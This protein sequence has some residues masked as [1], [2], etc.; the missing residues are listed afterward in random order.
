MGNQFDVYEDSEGNNHIISDKNDIYNDSLMGDNLSDFAVLKTLNSYEGNN[1][2][3]KVRSLKNDKIYAMKKIELNKIGNNQERQ[4]C[5]QEMEK[6]K[7]LKHPHLLR[8]YKTF[9]D[10]NDLYMI[11]E[12]MNNSD[13]NSF[14][15]AHQKLR[16]KIKEEEIWNFI[17]QCLSGLEYLHRENLAYLAI[18]PCNIFLNNEQKLK[19]G[20][21]YD[22]PKLADKYYDINKDIHFIGLYFYKMCFSH[23]NFVE[24]SKWINDFQIIKNI[25]NDTYSKDLIDIIFKMI[26]DDPKKKQS[27]AQLY[28]LVKDKYV[29]RYT[30]NTSIEAV[31]RCL[32]SYP[33]FTN[34]IKKEE[35][36]YENNKNK[37]HITYWYLKTI[38]QFSQNYNLNDCFEEFRRAVASE[39]PK[40]DTSKEIN[41]I[42]LFSFLLEKMHKEGNKKIKTQ[43]NNNQNNQYIINSIYNVEEEDK[44]NKEQVFNKFSFYLKSNINSN[45]SN[46]FFGIL[47]TK[48]NCKVCRNGIYSFNSFFIVPFD[49]TKFMNLQYFDLLNNGFHNQYHNGIFLDKNKYHIFCDRCL[50]EQDHTEFNR[51]YSINNH[52]TI[53]FYRGVNYQINLN[54]NFPEKLDINNYVEDIQMRPNFYLVGSLNR[55]VENGKENYVFFTRDSNNFQMWKTSFGVNIFNNAPIDIIQNSGQIIMLFYNRIK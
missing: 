5:F 14:I 2:I 52:L 29:Q 54:I 15:S 30:N 17:L 13:L 7:A 22:T 3:S 26:E 19:I 24:N 10:N 36:Y 53:Y 35:K 9:Q 1:D 39:N 11:F 25:V 28:K 41:P 32:Y 37:F 49:L 38:K 50:T 34:I 16:K 55:V 48:R 20:L 33:D 12:Y 51:Y 44:T 21:L 6:L 45:I 47:K 43:I 31:L 18:R 8:Y 40:L 23:Y 4:L 42:Y 46:N 27:S